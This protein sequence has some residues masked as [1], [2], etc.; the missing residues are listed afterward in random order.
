MCNNAV[1]LYVYKNC[2][3]ED[4]QYLLL[5]L[6]YMCIYLYVPKFAISE[7]VY[8][9]VVLCHSRVIRSAMLSLP[10][11]VPWKTL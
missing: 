1:V 8:V 11:S 4:F 6:V 5:T 10:P 2:A 3:I 7:I 9:I